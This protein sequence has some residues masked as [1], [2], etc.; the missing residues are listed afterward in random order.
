MAQPLY[1]P[2]AFIKKPVAMK[3]PLGRENMMLISPLNT[4]QNNILARTSEKEGTLLTSP[5]INRSGFG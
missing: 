5:C 1:T 2:T 3:S 4:S